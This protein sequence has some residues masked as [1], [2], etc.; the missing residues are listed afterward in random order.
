MI[1]LV[2]KNKID[3]RVY[4]T[5]PKAFALF[6]LKEVKEKIVS[7]DIIL[8]PSTPFFREVASILAVKMNLPLISD[9]TELWREN[10]LVAKKPSV[11]GKNFARYDLDPDKSYILLVKGMDGVQILKEEAFLVLDFDGYLEEVSNMEEA[12]SYKVGEIFKDNSGIKDIKEAEIIFSGGRGIMNIESFEALRKLAEKYDA[13]VGA[14]RPMVD[15]GW[16]AWEEQVGQTGSFVH[17]KVYVAFGISGAVQHITGIEKSRNI[18]A[19]NLN[20]ESPI[21]RYSSHGAYADDNSI[22]RNMLNLIDK[23]KN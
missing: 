19:I 18:I 16:A 10:N 12:G 5:N 9:C 7:Q 14:S 2:D 15:Q 23:E 21:F 13:A 22:I 6:L 8:I 1:Y 20:K 3:P 4:E 17:P 11:D